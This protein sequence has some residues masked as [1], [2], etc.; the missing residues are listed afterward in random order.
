MEKINLTQFI[1]NSG[2]CSRRQAEELIRRGEVR[3]NGRL[4]V[5]GLKIDPQKDKIEANGQL[6]KPAEK[7]VYYLVNKPIGYT[8]T[9]KD[10]HAE[11]KVIDLVP[12]FPR[13]WPV[14]RLD[15]DSRGLIILTNDGDLTY[16]LT[17]PK[18]EH[19]KEYLVTLNKPITP[20]LLLKLKQGVKLE[21]GLAKV[22]SM[23]QVSP[24][25]LSI[26]I[27]QG[28]KRQI[29]RMV[30]AGGYKVVDLVR[31]RIGKIKLGELK[32]GKY[33]ELKEVLP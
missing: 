33:K 6:I 23:K 8:C 27:H 25:K 21:E 17:H 20:E 28:W 19:P 4:A 12:P 2:L 16:K 3:V 7:K 24:T 9:V 32:E 1:S 14:G 15:R 11:K 5:L 13:V 10:I 22:D 26:T 30:E 31:V 29:R 18:F